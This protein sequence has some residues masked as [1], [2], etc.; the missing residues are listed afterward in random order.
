MHLSGV[1]LRDFRIFE[2]ARLECR[3]GFNLI[4][5]DN[6]AGKSSLLE[7]IF[8]LGR[9]GSHRAAPR[10][11]LRD[12]AS[13]WSVEGQVASAHAPPQR[14][15]V[16]WAEGETAIRWGTAAIGVS[17]LV[18]KL[19]VQILD[20]A[21]HRLVDEGP[22]VRR[23]FIDWGL[24]HVEQSFIGVWR[25]CQRALRQRNAALRSGEAVSAIT[26]WD[27]ELAESGEALNALRLH[28]LV[29]LEPQFQA[30]LAAL[31]PDQGWRFDFQRGWP[32]ERNY[33][34]VLQEGLERDRRYGQT[35][36]GPHRA[37][38]VF[39]GG[40]AGRRARGR[41]SR[42]QQKLLVCGFAL[43]QCEL[44]RQA[45]GEAPIVLLDDFAAELSSAFQE[46]LAAALGAYSGQKFVAALERTAALAAIGEA[47]VFHVEH[48]RVA[49]LVK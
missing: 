2:D 24:F 30:A 35:L 33:L 11:L 17:E 14:V 43:S 39:S 1:Q 46:R 25:R 47:L 20:P 36:Q 42:G 15:R 23:R 18:R 12:G 44:V 7:A 5:G 41:I 4:L 26:A 32:A 16:A 22:G 13:S 10:L 29:A 6:G 31:L 37:E 21:M 34:E 8:V 28:Y 27:R 38:V 48:G 49:A 3:A 45:S 19:P 9:G 40:A